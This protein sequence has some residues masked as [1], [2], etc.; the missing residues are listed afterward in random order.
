M[1]GFTL[2]EIA[3]ALKVTLSNGADKKRSVRGLAPLDLA[4]KEHV[5]FLDNAKYQKEAKTTKAAAVFIRKQEANL[6]P[7]GVIA[8]VTDN[9]YAAFAKCLQLF[10]PVVPPIAGV[11]AQAVVAHTATVHKTACLEAG[12]VVAE[13]AK[14][15]ARTHVQ[16]NTVIGKNVVIGDDCIIGANATIL[17]AIVGDRCL[18]H[19][20][21]CIGQDG[22]GFAQDGKNIIKIPQIGTVEIG[23]D[24]ELGANV[25]IDRGA[26]KNTVIGQGCKLDNQVQVAHNVRMGKNCRIAGQTGIAGSAVLGENVTIGGQSGIVGHIELADFVMVAGKSAVTKSITVA[27]SVVSGSPAMPIKRWRKVQATISK[28]SKG[29]SFVTDKTESIK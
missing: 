9:P 18:F 27:G 8:L 29:K 1:A 7:K 26:L 10:Y 17:H 16:A 24:V 28:L 2:A 15:G 3:T 11:D 25:T 23:D 21:V 14:I 20:G 6:L 19:A 13:S 5:S 4:T 22:F 12:V